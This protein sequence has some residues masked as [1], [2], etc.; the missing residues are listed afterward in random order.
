[1]SEEYSPNDFLLAAENIY[2]AFIEGGK[3]VSLTPNENAWLRLAVIACYNAAFHSVYFNLLKDSE[4]NK[5]INF[6]IKK[7]KANLHRYI[8]E[9]AVEK[10]GL[11]EILEL[12]ELTIKAQF[13][14]SPANNITIKDLERAIKIASNI[15][16]KFKS[17]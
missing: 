7:G 8:I 14:L 6:L 17:D 12:Y 3:A 4:I 13:L 2:I 5:E 16:S 1:M 9:K 11:D 10:F 15:I